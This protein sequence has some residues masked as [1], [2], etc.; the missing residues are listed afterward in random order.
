MFLILDT[1]TLILGGILLVFVLVA[2]F[3]DV[4]LKKPK[5]TENPTVASNEIQQDAS[6]AEQQNAEADELEMDKPTQTTEIE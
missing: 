1:T 2:T 3:T 6:N 4:F 5:R